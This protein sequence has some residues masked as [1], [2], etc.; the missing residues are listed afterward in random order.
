[1]FLYSSYI[2]SV[3]RKKSL[4][5]IKLLPQTLCTFFFDI[6]KNDFV[7]LLHENCCYIAVFQGFKKELIEK[8][9]EHLKINPEY[10]FIQPCFNRKK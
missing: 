4:I 8:H 2:V 1:M 7:F 3:Q 6:I 5:R 10:P 9:L